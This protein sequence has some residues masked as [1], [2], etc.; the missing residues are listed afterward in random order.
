MGALPLTVAAVPADMPN[1]P[2]KPLTTEQRNQ[3]NQFIDYLD[4]TGYKGNSLLDD[5]D[6]ALGKQLMSKYK[7]V[8]PQFNLTYDN[9][10]DVQQA[11]QQYRTE[12]LKQIHS[13]KAV[14]EG[15]KSDNDFMPGLSKVD[16]W[17]G[18][19]TSSYK[20]PQASFT[21]KTPEGSTTTNYGTDMNAYQAAKDA[22]LNKVR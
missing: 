8:N 16:G 11:L 12:A 19:K 22:A 1:P 9:V 13:G 17:L 21:V 3:W 14:V 7:Q 18:S 5:K 6:K 15:V 4:K 20:F 2:G 10:P